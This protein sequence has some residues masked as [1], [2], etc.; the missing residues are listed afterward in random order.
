MLD[1]IQ[2]DS[3]MIEFTHILEDSKPTQR[4]GSTG[5]F[6]QYFFE[7]FDVKVIDEGLCKQLEKFD[8]E[9]GVV[10]LDKATI[11]AKRKLE[12]TFDGQI[13]ET[14]LLTEYLFRETNG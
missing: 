9:S 2:R 10:L 7:L 8:P 3:L 11:Q 13:R 4:T 12:Q 6:T 14:K 5:L 1:D